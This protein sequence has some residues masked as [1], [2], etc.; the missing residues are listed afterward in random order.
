MVRRQRC[1]LELAVAVELVGH[2]R[3]LEIPFQKL[4]QLVEPKARVADLDLQQ[5]L[6]RGQ[7]VAAQIGVRGET[8]LSRCRDGEADG[9]WNVHGLPM[10]VSKSEI[11]QVHATLPESKRYFRGHHRKLYV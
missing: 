8:R 3:G 5:Q 1:G 2:I 11:V 10:R 4:P 9:S 6:R 7:L